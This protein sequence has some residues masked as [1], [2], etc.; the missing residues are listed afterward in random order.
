ME[1]LMTYFT[2]AAS[3]VRVPPTAHEQSS[4]DRELDLQ[5]AGKALQDSLDKSSALWMVLNHRR[6]VA[7]YEDAVAH[8]A[9]EGEKVTNETVMKRMGVKEGLYRHCKKLATHLELRV[10][11]G[12]R[13]PCLYH[14]PLI[15]LRS[16]LD[17][18][19]RRL[20]F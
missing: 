18:A 11:T 6:M 16:L 15:L 12:A 4:G 14:P 20:G 5:A 7:L 19:K 1:V 17:S 9:N 3:C 8:V 10:S 13:L 2:L